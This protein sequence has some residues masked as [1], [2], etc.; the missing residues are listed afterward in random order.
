MLIWLKESII[1]NIDMHC[2][3]NIKGIYMINHQDYGAIKA[4]LECSGNPEILGENNKKDIEVNTK[5]LL[6]AEKY[7]KYKFLDIKPRLGLIDIN[8]TVSNLVNGK[9]TIV[10]TGKGI[11]P[12]ELW[13]NY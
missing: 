3:D 7:I 4:Y 1:K 5:I 12:L 9:W 2:L 10:Y 13:W 11:D 8:G 6:I